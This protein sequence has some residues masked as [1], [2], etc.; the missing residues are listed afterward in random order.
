V[1]DGRGSPPRRSRQLR[2]RLRLWRGL[3]RQRWVHGVTSYIPQFPTNLPL[4][5]LTAQGLILDPA[6]AAGFAATNP[7]AFEVF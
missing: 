5:S 1:P 3:C 6:A 4:V 2:A 7:I